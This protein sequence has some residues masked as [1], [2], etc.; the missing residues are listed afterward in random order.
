MIRFQ[1]IG[2]CILQLSHALMAADSVVV[3][4]NVKVFDGNSDQL[5]GPTSV[6]VEGNKIVKIGQG[7]LADDKMLVIEGG[8]RT[9]MPGLID[10]HVHLA[11]A[12]I[13]MSTLLTA[14]SGYIH[15]H[16]GKEAERTLMRGFTSVRDASGPVF[17]LKKAI[18]EGTIPGPRIYPSG[19]MISQTAGHG[20]FRMPYDVPKQGLSRAEVFGAGIVAD[21]VPAV[22]KASREQLLQGAS[23]L[24]LA[25]G[26][27]V[28]SNFDPL[29][30][31]QYSDE[32]LEAAVNAADD[33]G[34]YV[35]VHAYTPKAIRRAV[36]A[37][38]KCIEHGQLMDDDVARLLAEKKVWLSTQPFLDDED[39]NPMKDPASRK[40]Q[41]EMT[42]GTDLSIRLAINHKVKIA[43]G[44]DSLFDANLAAKQGKQLAKMAKWFSPVQ[45][46]RMATS[47]NGELLALSGLRNPYPGKLG[48]VEEGALADLILVEGN[49]LEDPTVIS[50]PEAKFV[51]IMK[52]GRIYKNAI[53]TPKPR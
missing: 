6:L 16:A 29:D 19:A 14:D 9:L 2:F 35:T 28:A 37:G 50:A 27:G 11:M 4:K 31:S 5:I 45:I 47:G 3:F 18:D 33:W 51:V 23:Q 30:V 10:V 25:A 13:P 44:T 49:P 1:F 42:N 32:E 20:D 12:S 40:K 15:L 41:I 53:A 34:T 48:V 21:G 38:V 46:M 26:G 22:M 43:W 24:K 7:I 17:G 36:N 52:D 39:A 8:S